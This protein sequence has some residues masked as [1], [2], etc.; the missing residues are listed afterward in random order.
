MLHQEGLAKCRRCGSPSSPPP[1]WPVTLQAPILVP[2][3]L[4]VSVPRRLRNLQQT[5]SSGPHRDKAEPQ[6]RAAPDSRTAAPTTCSAYPVKFLTAHPSLEPPHPQCSHCPEATSSR[7]AGGATGTDL[8]TKLKTVPAQALQA[9]EHSSLQVTRSIRLPCPQPTSPGHRCCLRTSIS[10]LPQAPEL[11]CHHT[12]APRP[13]GPV[14]WRSPL[15]QVPSPLPRAASAA[16]RGS[17]SGKPENQELKAHGTAAH[18]G[19][20]RSALRTHHQQG[21]AFQSTPG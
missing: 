2:L 7:A 8:V 15:G 21:R 13:P 4:S 20:P 14:G 1:S 9:Q 18:L 10:Q 17:P 12:A 19:G 11:L 5:A 16:V 3:V 6:S